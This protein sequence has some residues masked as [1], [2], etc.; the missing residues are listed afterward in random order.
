MTQKSY[1]KVSGFNSRKKELHLE[2]A[3]ITILIGANGSGKSSAISALRK[4]KKIASF[5]DNI[6]DGDI[7]K[8]LQFNELLKSDFGISKNKSLSYKFPLSLSN[9]DGPFEL[10]LNF[11]SIDSTKIALDNFSII[12]TETKK[13]LF[14]M[15]IKIKNTALNEGV[16]KM[17]FDYNFILSNY[18]K[19][20]NN[21]ISVDDLFENPEIKTEALPL[22]TAIEDANLTETMGELTEEEKI[23]IKEY[24]ERISN[25]FEDIKEKIKFREINFYEDSPIGGDRVNLNVYERNKNINITSDPFIS[26]DYKNSETNETLEDF[27]YKFNNTFIR[28]GI[29]FTENV[30]HSFFLTTINRIFEQ[31]ENAKTLNLNHDLL[32]TLLLD[33]TESISLKLLLDKTDAI[34]K[35]SENFKI[36]IAKLLIL[37]ITSNVTSF[38]NKSNNTTYF[39]PNRFNNRED[40]TNPVKYAVSKAK[41][42]KELNFN[43]EAFSFFINYWF[44]TFGIKDKVNGVEDAVDFLT[45]ENRINKEGYGLRQIAPLIVALST[46]QI[47]KKPE[48][49]DPNDIQSIFNFSNNIQNFCTENYLIEEPEANLHPAL[50]SKLAD[51]FLD[52]YYKFGH[53]F[54]IE[55]HSE[56]IIRK[57]Q[58]HV[59]KGKVDPNLIKIY[60]F[61]MDETVREIKINSDGSLSDSFGPGFIDEAQ[62][63]ALE[64]FFGRLN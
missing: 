56:Y 32:I 47:P 44:K 64:L 51:L 18:F 45:N 40:E 17:Y 30:H 61:E 4:F 28:N 14:E 41:A 43:S 27:K 58:A 15:S 49:Y 8:K 5:T 23:I 1:F 11:C 2:L 16:F 10:S 34:L 59:G 21:R 24:L 42:Y 6:K 60:Y 53:R 62:N 31:K 25:G 63:L 12:N 57:L 38:F 26:I 50:Q 39:P 37:D 3:P 19:N 22:D 36:L 54:V 20:I 7:I 35:L 13:P 55:T 9:V 48:D 46:A 29:I 52:A 33:K